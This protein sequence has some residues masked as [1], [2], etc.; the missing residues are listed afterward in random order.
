MQGWHSAT[1]QILEKEWKGMVIKMKKKTLMFGLMI[2]LTMGF[3]TTASAA[4]ADK[5]VT[6]TDQN[7]IV[8]TDG[9]SDISSAFGDMAPGDTRTV[10]IRVQ[11]DNKHAASFFISQE[12]ISYLEEKGNAS[13]GAYT[14]DLKVG[15]A[16]DGTAVSLL[17]TVAGGYDASLK[18]NNQGLNGITELNDYQY[19]AELGSGEYTNVYLTLTI[20]GE[21]FDSTGAVNY[22]NATGKLEFNFRAYYEDREPVVVTQTVVKKGQN[23]IVKKIVDEIVP[24]A[25]YVKTGDPFS[26]TMVVVV[27]LAGIALIAFALK[28]R[29]AENR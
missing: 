16:N 11:N 25:G 20:D 4:E 15:K 2:A 1:E 28:R 10:T 9:Q 14:Y 19:L 13:G 18:A 23:T 5:T 22:E 12:T 7:E 24:L 27:L 3:A 29:K 6:L 8:Y 21:G 26:I 17:D